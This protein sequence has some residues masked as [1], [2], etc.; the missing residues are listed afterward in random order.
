MPCNQTQ[1]YACIAKNAGTTLTWL[2]EGRG[3]AVWRSINFAN[4]GASWTTPARDEDGKPKTKPSWQAAD[5]PERVIEDIAEVFV[6]IPRLVR[7]FRVGIRR[8]AQG[9]CLKVTDKGSRKIRAAVEKAGDDAW[10]EFDY[11]T[12]EALIFAPDRTLPIVD[13]AKENGL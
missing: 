11:D 13:W 3:L 2:R 12:Q 6:T 1:Q 4:L 10:H 8:G 9:M 7:K 5:T